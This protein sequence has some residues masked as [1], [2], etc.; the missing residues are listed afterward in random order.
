MP[1]DVELSLDD[2]YAGLRRHA[3][4]SQGLDAQAFALLKDKLWTFMHAEI[5][6]NEQ[7]FH[8]QVTDT[9]ARPPTLF[10]RAFR[11]APSPTALSHPSPPNRARQTRPECSL[12][13]PV[14]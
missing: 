2:A 6:P 1:G 3:R 13:W 14:P 9:P 5:Y 7:L 12:T 4:G 11:I 10:G 8:E